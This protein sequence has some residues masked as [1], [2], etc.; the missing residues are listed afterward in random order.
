MSL[1]GGSGPRRNNPGTQK[2]R[3]QSRNGKC[4]VKQT[5]FEH[6]N[7]SWS[8]SVGR[9]VARGATPDCHECNTE[10]FPTLVVGIAR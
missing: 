4:G 2:G 3:G 7:S 6:E 5:R 8:R 9:M 1:G 10:N